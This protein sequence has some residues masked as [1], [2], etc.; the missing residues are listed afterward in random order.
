MLALLAQKGLISRGTH[1]AISKA[2]RVDLTTLGRRALERARPLWAATEK[3]YFSQ[4]GAKGMA[5][6]GALPDE[7]LEIREEH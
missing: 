2:K 1:P 6:L 3:R 4:V 5:M 7:L